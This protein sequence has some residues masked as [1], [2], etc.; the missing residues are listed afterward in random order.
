MQTM[1]RIVCEKQYNR[2][3]LIQKKLGIKQLK[4]LGQLDEDAVDAGI[5]DIFDRD[6]ELEFNEV[7]ANMGTLNKNI[8]S[9]NQLKGIA[10]KVGVKST[11]GA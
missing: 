10:S 6:H 3:R 5:H 7:L 8:D 2:D 9:V 4:L 11:S 1:A